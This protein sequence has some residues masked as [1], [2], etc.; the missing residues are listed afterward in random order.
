M[1]AFFTL[2]TEDPKVLFDC[3]FKMCDSDGDGQLTKAE[4]VNTLYAYCNM[5]AGVGKGDEEK[6][7]A[8]TL[9]EIEKE[10]SEAFGERKFVLK[11]DI[12]GILE[13]SEMLQSIFMGL[14]CATTFGLVVDDADFD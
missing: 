14:H 12:R 11:K 4:L 8:H 1:L 7:P 13:K 9:D 10:I 5:V 3:I 2:Q 6:Q